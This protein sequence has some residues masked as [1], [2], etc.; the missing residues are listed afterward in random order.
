MISVVLLVRDEPNLA[1]FLLELHK[2]MSGVSGQ[3]EV[4][5]MMGDRETLHPEIPDHPNQKVVKTYGDRLERSILAGFSFARGTKIVICDAD[6]YHPINKIPEMI[7]LLD[8]YEMVVG[9]RYLSG[10]ELNLSRFRSLVSRCFVLYAHLLGSHHSDPTSGFF[11]VRK[12][13]VDKVTFKP[14][15]WKIGLEIEMKAKP[16]LIEIPIVPKPRTAGKSKTSMKTGLKL[17]RDMLIG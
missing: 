1:M 2:V 9:S 14:F 13:I 3:Y 17:M 12:E 7:E 4:L 11:A 6:G 8:T 16:K 5:V 10:G 15:T